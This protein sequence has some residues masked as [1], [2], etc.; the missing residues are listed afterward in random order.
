MDFDVDAHTIFLGLSGS[1]AYGT[2]RPGSDLD[3]RGCCVAPLDLRLSFR[4][5]FEQV[6]WPSEVPLG[7]RC[8]AALVRAAEHP[9]AGPSL[10]EHTRDLTLH[11]QSPEFSRDLL[12]FEYN[13][14]GL[15]RCIFLH[16][17]IQKAEEWASLLKDPAFFIRKPVSEREKAAVRRIY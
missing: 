10:A 6:T 1:H 17:N 7:P 3:L 14:Q 9:S 4:R 16:G 5:H 11:L 15:M 8:R 13:E 2:A 12:V